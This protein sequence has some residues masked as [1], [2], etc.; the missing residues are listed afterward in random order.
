MLSKNFTIK[1][2][3]EYQTLREQYNKLNME[4]NTGSNNPNYMKPRSEETKKKIS[5]S[6]KG[7]YVGENSSMYGKRG[8][9]SPWYGKHH[10][11]ETKA[12]I[13]ESHKGE[14]NPMYGKP[15]TRLGDKNS[16]ETNKKISEAQSIPVIDLTTGKEYYCMLEASKD[17]GCTCATISHHCKNGKP[18][19]GHILIYKE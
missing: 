3:V 4:N 7:K 9:L 5:E 10:S 11:E 2:P 1:D 19:K 14:K 15:G 8:I 18:L 16:L 6:R 12:K 13:S 17:L